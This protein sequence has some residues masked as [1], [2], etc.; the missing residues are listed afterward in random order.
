MGCTGIAPMRMAEVSR[1]GR[2]RSGSPQGLDGFRR[3]VEYIGEFGDAD[4]FEINSIGKL[5]HQEQAIATR[6]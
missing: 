5:A 4:H 3:G 6:S 2:E 1:S